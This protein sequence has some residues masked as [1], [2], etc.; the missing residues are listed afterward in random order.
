MSHATTLITPFMRLLACILIAALTPHALAQTDHQP[1]PEQPAFTPPDYATLQSGIV[2]RVLDQNSL[3]IEINKTQTRIDL[4]GVSGSPK[5]SPNTPLSPATQALSQ[6][7]LGETVLIQY[8]PSG[9][10]N[11]ANKRVA[12]LYRVPD[13]LF[14]NLE[15]VRQGHARHANAS[16]TIHTSLFEH[17][18]RRAQQLERGIWNPN[19]LV[20]NTPQLTIEAEPVSPSQSPSNPKPDSTVY[21]T[22]HGTKYHLHDCPHLTDSA[23]PTTREEVTSTHEPCKTCKPDTP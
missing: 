23:R 16:M 21:I 22:T 1:Q 11:H 17:Y 15:L 9:E 6:L 7:T 3:L 5:P 2:T 18:Q 4:L 20:P 8:D 13:H 10:L 19:A 12:Y 14:I